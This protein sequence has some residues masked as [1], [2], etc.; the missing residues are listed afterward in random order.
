MAL[1]L[2]WAC[3]GHAVVTGGETEEEEGTS[4]LKVMSL[5]GVAL[6]FVWT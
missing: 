4:L 5:I 1:V 3:Y 6:K 2:E